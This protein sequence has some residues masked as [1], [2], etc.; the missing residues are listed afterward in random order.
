MSLAIIRG[1]GQL[2]GAGRNGLRH[3]P[4]LTLIKTPWSEHY[5]LATRI[6]ER[7]PHICVA[8]HTTD[9]SYNT[10]TAFGTEV[11][12]GAKFLARSHLDLP[13]G[14]KIAAIGIISRSDHF[15][16]CILT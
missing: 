9:S 4:G 3:K 1:K 5:A 10:E 7:E 13:R 12:I 15:R 16:R 2:P 11:E 8:R 6:L 14:G